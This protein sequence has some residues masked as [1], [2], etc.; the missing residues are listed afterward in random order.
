MA[1]KGF[2]NL[3]VLSLESRRSR[4]M[5]LLIANHGGQATVVASTREV[6][7]GPNAEESAFAQGIVRGEFQVV[8]FM[9]GVGTRALAQAIEPAC[10]R[11]RMV[12]ALTAGAWVVADSYRGMPWLAVN[13]R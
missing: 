2:G 8:I 1:G 12:A 10:P 13:Q 11:E 4:E 6:P 3:R 9:T 5:G 7:S